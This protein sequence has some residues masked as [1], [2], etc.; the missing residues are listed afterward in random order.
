MGSPGSGPS[1]YSE[2]PA[3]VADQVTAAFDQLPEAARGAHPGSPTNPDLAKQQGVADGR[4]IASGNATDAD[5]Q[6]IAA[7]LAAAGITAEDVAAINAGRQVE[8]SAEQWNYLHEFYNTAG[9]NGTASMSERLTALHDTTATVADRLNTLA[10]PNVHSAGQDPLR[11][12]ASARPAGC[13][14]YPPTCAT[15]RPRTTRS[16]PA[17]PTPTWAPTDFRESHT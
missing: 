9:L 15:F 6:R 7:R 1:G 10:N 4:L 16:C 14:N 2:S 12:P 17:A 3:T 13:T 11:P 8:L 5:L